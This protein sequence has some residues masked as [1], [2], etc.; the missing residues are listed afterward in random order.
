MEEVF[1]VSSDD[2]STRSAFVVS[3]GR[4]SCDVRGSGSYWRDR[5]VADGFA[6][7]LVLPLHDGFEPLGL[8]G[9][10][11]REVDRAFCPAD[12]EALGALAPLL[13]SA[14]EAHR[15]ATA[16][17]RKAI[18]LRTLGNVRG[19]VLV[20][21]RLE[22]RIMQA[23]SSSGDPGWSFPPHRVERAIVSLTR[24]IL[25][26]TPREVARMLPLAIGDAVII[27]VAPLATSPSSAPARYAAVHLSHA[28]TREAARLRLS[29][30][31]RE[32]AA[33]LA[34][35]HSGT[36][37]ALICRLSPHTVR[38]FTRRIYTKLGIVNRP[39]LV[40]VVMRAGGGRNDHE[41]S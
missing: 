8:I 23:S 28:S 10:E 24:R 18:A 12:A 21:D 34:A 7:A 37:V 19:P 6:R 1:G 22:G 11:R 2:M 15:R 13:V 14:V 40:Q 16:L 32:V 3:S 4:G 27:A 9:I 20:V 29:P 36:D 26:E 35:G 25:A 5:S 41:S 38:T 30:R 31:E 33:L 17:E 39:A